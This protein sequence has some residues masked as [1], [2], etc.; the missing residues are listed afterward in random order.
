M[1]LLAQLITETN[2]PL[3]YTDTETGIIIDRE[4]HRITDAARQQIGHQIIDYNVV[5]GYFLLDNN[6]RIYP[7]SLINLLDRRQ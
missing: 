3:I 7:K 5:H 2:N 4:T 1:D 6:E